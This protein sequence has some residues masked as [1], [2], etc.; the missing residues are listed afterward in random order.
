[1][2]TT[3]KRKE[4]F[5]KVLIPAHLFGPNNFQLLYLFPMF[6]LKHF[7]VILSVTIQNLLS[8]LKIL[9]KLQFSLL[10]FFFFFYLRQNDFFVC[11]CKYATKILF[12]F[13]SFYF[14]I[15]SIYVCCN[16]SSISMVVEFL[17]WPCYIPPKCIYSVV[18]LYLT[19]HRSINFTYL[20][21]LCHPVTFNKS[22]A[23]SSLV[24]PSFYLWTT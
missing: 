11:V 20:K 2:L 4:T 10:L 21:T 18:T 7:L 14:I 1:M 17:L 13:N 16:L 8:S 5:I 12:K 9:Q 24:H 15:L 22:S 23:L 3:L 6:G 19:T